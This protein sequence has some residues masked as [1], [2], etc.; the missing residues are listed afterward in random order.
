TI[1]NERWAEIVGYTLEELDPISIETWASL[2]HPDDLK[3]SGALLEQHFQ[4]KLAFYDVKCRMKHKAGHWVWVHDRGRVVSWTDDG[5]PLMMYGTHADITEQ[6]QAEQQLQE[7]KWLFEQI[8]EQTMAGYWDWYIQENTEY[9]SPSF[10][11]MF[12][13]SDDEMENSPEAWQKI[14]FPDDLSKVLVSFEQHIASRGE[15]PFDNVVRYHHKNGTVVWVRCV[16][17]VIEWSAD[18]QPIRMVGSHMDLTLEMEV[19]Q[20][21]QQSRDQFQTLVAN[22]PGITYRCLADEHWTMVYMSGSIDPL[23]GY[24]ASDFIQNKVRSYASVIH[25]EDASRLEDEIAKA[26]AEKNS[27]LLQYRVLHKDGSVRYVE[28]RGMGEY[29]QDGSL[30]YLDGFILDVTNEKTLKRQLLK[31]AE[32]LP[33]VVY[34][35][36]QWPDGRSS[37]PYASANLKKIYGVSPEEAKTDASQVFQCILPEDLP[38]VT[39]SIG[40]SRVELSLWQHEYRV[41]NR[42]GEV[43]W[44]SGRAMPE[45][46]LDGSVLW[47]G[48]IYDITD[49]KQH[50]LELERA[51]EQLH[52]AQQRLELSSQQA[53][54][55]YWQASLKTGDLW[56]SPMIYDVFGFDAATT[57]PS[58]ALFKSTVHPDDLHLVEASETIAK[59]TGLHDVVHRI[60]RPD[61]EIR[62]VHEL[63]QMLPESGN[64]DLM[65]IGSVQDVTERMRLQQMKDEFISTVSHELRTPL[66]SIN[67]ALKLLQATQSSQLSGKGQKLLDVATSNNARL[68]QLIND[69]LDIE[70]LIAGKMNFELQHQPLLPLLEQALADHA[71]YIAKSSLTLSMQIS[72][73]AKA[74]TIFVDEHRLQQ[75]LANLLSNAIKFSPEQGQVQLQARVADDFIEIAVQ[76]QGPG[77]PEG[78]KDK[79][80]Q[81]FSQADA[82]SAKEKGGTGLGLALCKELVEGMQ[83]S[84]GFE[85]KAGS[86]ARFYVRFPRQA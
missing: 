31:L 71:T 48:Y 14:I 27:W 24:P 8:L 10:K 61:G 68:Q 80:F 57:E 18:N 59:Q 15:V 45:A 3:E 12:G 72:E 39:D 65:M 69:L 13:Y 56:W 22:I 42:Q 85:S 17:K 50:Y 21:L 4:G 49:T 11:L 29:H 35:F 46:M 76:D 75:I 82:S 74:V 33:G 2:A 44:L 20:A 43:M 77:I 67:G 25:P 32:Q 64:P 62:W 86:G 1:F 6:K 73:P 28:E 30:R 60:I 58:V 47:H 40:R 36:Q 7:Q 26:V 16:G 51:N 81:R 84:I 23:S 9:L 41:V 54:I 79:L 19:R 83:G 63:A 52:L 38:A 34:Q 66:T 78:F 70:K 5:K 37:F 55:G 53:Q